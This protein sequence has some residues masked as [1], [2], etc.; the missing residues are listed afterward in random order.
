MPD[1]PAIVKFMKPLLLALPLVLLFSSSNARAA[2]EF[3]AIRCGADVAQAVI[4]RK[5]S[6]GNASALERAH[7][8]LGLKNLGGDGMPED[9]YLLVEW[10]ICQSAYVF[11]IDQKTRRGVIADALALPETLRDLPQSL[12][13]A[14]CQ[15][16][17]KPAE[18]HLFALL[19]KEVHAGRAL[20]KK[21]WRM[22][23]ASMKFVAVPVEGLS[24]AP[25]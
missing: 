19:D 4:G 8:E 14:D 13:G 15:R 12:P 6:A 10:Q 11:L 20:A 7:R 3:E 22:D 24:C 2:D 1:T 25:E 5:A 21:A 23:P 17:G 16:Q 18:P 9:P